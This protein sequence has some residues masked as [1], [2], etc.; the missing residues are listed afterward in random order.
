MGTLTN[1]VI[2]VT[3]TLGHDVTQIRRWIEANGG[4]YSLNVRRGVTHL[5]T[6]KDAWKKAADAVQEANKLGVL[7]VNFDWLED[8]LHARRKLAEKQYTW[9]N[10]TQVKRRERQIKKLGPQMSTKQFNDGCEEIKK[11][12]GSGTSKSCRSRVVVRKPRKSTS[13]LTAHMHVPYVSAGEDLAR[14]RKERE[15]AKAKKKEADEATAKKTEEIKTIRAASAAPATAQSS[16]SAADSV[17][18]PASAS[19]HAL[20]TTSFQHASLTPGTQA[21][22]FSLKD[23][24][25]YYLDST[26]LEYKIILTRCNLRANEITRYHLSIP[27]SHT[28]PHMYCTFIEYF[29]PGIG[30]TAGSGEACIQALLEFEKT[31]HEGLVSGMDTDAPVDDHQDDK[32]DVIPAA[33]SPPQ[34]I[35]HHHPDAERLRALLTPAT[36]S[37]IP[38]PANQ[39]YKKL[40]APM[41]SDFATAWRTFRHAF[42]D[43]TLL[44]WEERFDI[45]K[46]LYKTR[47]SHFAIEPFVYVRPKHGLPLGLRV[48]QDG[49]FQN[50]TLAPSDEDGS[51]IS[52]VSDQGT[53][54]ENDDGYVYNTFNLPSLGAPLGP[55]IIGQAV[56]RDVK[57]AREAAEKAKKRSDEAEET[58]L[59]KLGHARKIDNKKRPNYSRPLFNGVNGRPTIDAWGH[60]KRGRGGAGGL[61]GSGLLGGGVV[62][63]NKEVTKSWPYESGRL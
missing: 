9:E 7:V 37:T 8:S 14:R 53:T 32:T 56:A 10:I 63:K 28:K 15:A 58:R 5:V 62:K 42:R 30:N 25:H 54:R 46:A 2:A 40:I 57:A 36:A 44:S 38:P 24:Y 13:V 22:K 45:S 50:Q 49:L 35:T 31:F 1:L 61:Y 59:R 3:G 41:S 52:T 12:T 55:G 29:P 20:S 16:A 26:G 11:N 33:L 18:S 27:E 47:A 4:R 19:S 23:L 21:K 39:L 48:Q 60:Q 34:R 6:G 17:S 51:I 43:L